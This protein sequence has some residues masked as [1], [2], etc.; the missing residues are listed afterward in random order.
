MHK[1][2]MQHKFLEVIAG[3]V[4]PEEWVQWWNEHKTVLEMFL[5]IGDRQKIMPKSWSTSYCG[6]LKTQSGIAHYF[7][8]Q[9]NPQKNLSDFYEKKANE[10]ENHAKEK[11]MEAFHKR[12][13]LERQAWD[14]YLE[15]HPTQAVDFNWKSRLGTPSEQKPL[16]VLPHKQ[17][18]S[19]SE[20][21]KENDKELK[22]RL[23]E[24]IQVK[25]LPLA[26]AYGMK[27]V[28]T[29]TFLKEN[30]GLVSCLKFIGYFR[31]GGYQ[32][33]HYYLCPIYAIDT[34]I[35]GIPGFIT[36]GERY[37]KM[38]YGWGEIQYVLNKV[39]SHRIDKI[40][41]KF[42]D[43]LE[44]LA[45][46]IFPEWQK[47]DNIETYFSKERL[48]YLNA[49][50]IGPINVP[51]ENPMWDFSTQVK[52]PWR[53]DEYLFGVWDLLSGR[54]EEGYRRIEECV[55]HG[56]EYMNTCL[57]DTPKAYADKR[58]PMAVLYY[59]AALFA[60]TNQIADAEERHQAI[61][62]TYEEVCCFMRYYHGLSKRIDR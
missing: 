11:A 1:N 44:F 20:Q 30:N 18:V 21:I 37:Q 35:L 15:K 34:G 52:H 47:I 13:A 10:E 51:T 25:I 8:T 40:N 22:L 57:K 6:M 45:D 14:K 50:K 17:G 36:N 53:A 33:I 24:N 60:Q 43:I 42:D 12:T 19:H 61:L 7:Y 9:G 29:N 38:M 41:Q 62:N 55:V 5:T 54:E 16:Q 23:K 32:S 4:E 2:E 27:K 46:G 58:F 59:N 48:D 31:G 26:K 49:T 56:E 3:K 28:G 39:D